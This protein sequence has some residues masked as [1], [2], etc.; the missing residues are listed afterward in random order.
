MTRQ[1]DMWALDSYSLIRA[2]W[3]L[4]AML[5]L[6]VDVEDGKVCKRRYKIVPGQMKRKAERKKK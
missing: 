2:G 5:F 4:E 6:L 1:K 3:E